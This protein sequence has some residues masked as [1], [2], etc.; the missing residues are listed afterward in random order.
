MQP[1]INGAYIGGYN[2]GFIDGQ[3]DILEELAEN[4]DEDDCEWRD[5]RAWLAKKYEEIMSL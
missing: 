1:E 3:Q 4:F 5:V 2:N